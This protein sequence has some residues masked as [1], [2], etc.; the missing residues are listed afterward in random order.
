[1]FLLKTVPLNYEE[2]KQNPQRITKIETIINIF[3][4][5][6]IKSQQKEMIGIKMRNLMLELLLIL[7]MLKKKKYVLL[8]FQKIT[9]TVK[10]KLFF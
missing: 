5:L 3:N 1:M 2:I 4:W 7:N 8:T 10:N 9:Q 6:E